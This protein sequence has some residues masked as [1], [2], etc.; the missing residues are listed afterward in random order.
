MR[1]G[2]RRDISTSQVKKHPAPP[3]EP[4]GAACKIRE[5]VKRQETLLMRSRASGRGRAPG[6]PLRT[7][8]PTAGRAGW[9]T[10]R[11]DDPYLAYGEIPWKVVT[12]NDGDGYGRTVVRIGESEES[13]GIVR[14]C[15]E[16]L[17]DGPIG[18]EAPKKAPTGRSSPGTRPRRGTRPFHP[19]ERHRQGRPA[20]HPDP[21]PRQLDLGGDVPGEPEHRGYP[22]YRCSH[23]SLPLLHLKDHHLEGEGKGGGK[24]AE[25]RKD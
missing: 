8:G 20:R 17:P 11:R 15:L 10:I 23:R 22:C 25:Q 7:V 2:V 9:T 5:M 24:G 18:V 6:A 1:I 21:D 16:N 4:Q 19:D 12:S 3:P 14:D 13:L